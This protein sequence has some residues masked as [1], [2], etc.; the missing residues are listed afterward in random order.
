MLIGSDLYKF[1]ISPSI[2]YMTL[3]VHWICALTEIK[4]VEVE[5]QSSSAQQYNHNMQIETAD[6][7]RG[8]RWDLL[9][10]TAACLSEAAAAPPSPIAHYS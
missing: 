8:S 10:L 2:V 1:C 9:T 4:I 3:H 7:L 6:Q 5:I